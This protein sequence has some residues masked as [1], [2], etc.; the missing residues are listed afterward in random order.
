MWPLGCIVVTSVLE[1]SEA[2]DEV[3]GCRQAAAFRIVSKHF[4]VF[5]ST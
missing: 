5:C 2:G 1:S 3:K 4:K